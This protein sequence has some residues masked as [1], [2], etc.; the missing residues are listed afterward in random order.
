MKTQIQ[1]WKGIPGYEGM[2][3]VSNFGNVKSLNY[4]KTGKER[5]LKPGIDSGYYRIQLNKYGKGKTFRVHQLV[6]MAFKNHI[7]CG[8][9]LV[10]NHIDN[11]PLNNHVDNL[12]LVPNRYN[13]QCH[14]KDCGVS[15]NK[16]GKY[17]TSIQING[18]KVHLG[19]FKNKK[20]ALNMY[21]KALDNINKFNGNDKE[22]REMLGY[23]YKAKG[24][25]LT[26]SGKY[27][28][29]ININGKTVSLGYFKN[30]EDAINQYQK[31]LANK[32]FYNGNN[33]EFKDLLNSI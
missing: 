26:P 23:N 6:C 11:N 7:P 10:V 14:K 5:L 28:S 13:S 27:Q 3:Q 32:H 30:E 9:N 2:Y 16:N 4:N 25:Y 1:E 18:K 20:D 8:M 22:F 33:K 29:Q 15:L 12:E 17:G 31:A 21:Q 19:N 24:Y